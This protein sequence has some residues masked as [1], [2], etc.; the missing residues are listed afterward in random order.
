RFLFLHTAPTLLYT[1]SLH[2]ALPISS[3]GHD[4]IGRAMTSDAPGLF[5]ASEM[6]RSELPAD[7]QH[8]GDLGRLRVLHASEGEQHAGADVA[9]SEEHTSE[10]QSRGH[11]VCRLLLE[12]K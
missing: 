10:L 7:A 9:R 3:A 12:K 6:V 4:S 2:D 5:E 1:L 8:L 11:L